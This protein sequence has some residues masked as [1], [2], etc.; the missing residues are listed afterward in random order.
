MFLVQVDSR[1]FSVTVHFNK[2]TPVDFMSEAYKKACK[3]HTQLPEGGILIFVTG[4][5]LN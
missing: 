2:K 1:Q 5:D 4:E 3:I